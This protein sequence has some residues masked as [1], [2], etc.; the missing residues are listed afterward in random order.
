MSTDNLQSLL[1]QGNNQ[2]QKGQLAEAEATFKQIL[3]AQPNNHEAL[4]GLGIVALRA[5]QDQHAASFIAQALQLAPNN[6]RYYFQL[7]TIYTRAGNLNM[8]KNCHQKALDLAPDFAE[9]ML[10]LGATEC[11]LGN[12][13]EG[14]AL[15]EKAIKLKPEIADAHLLLGKVY[16]SI[17]RYRDAGEQFDE[18]LKIADKNPELLEHIMQQCSKADQHQMAITY[19][20]R[21]LAVGDAGNVR[22]L[23]TL[24]FSHEKLGEMDP[25]K[26][27]FEKAL[28]KLP[29]SAELHSNLGV[30]LSKSGNIPE[31]IK[32]YRK[33]IELDADFV[34]AYR[35][36][37]AFKKFTPEDKEIID[38]IEAMLDKPDLSEEAEAYL[39]FSLG[40]AYDDLKEYD[41]AFEHYARGNELTDKQAQFDPDEQQ[42]KFDAT[43]RVFTKDFFKKH[44]ARGSDSNRPIFI[45]GMPRSGTTL[46]EQIISAH[47]DVAGGD[48]LEHISHL[49][50]VA[51]Q[52]IA[53]GKE[54]PDCMAVASQEQLGH[55]AKFYLDQLATIS[56]AAPHVTDKLPYNF[57]YLGLIA[58]LFPNA[59]IV[60]CRRHPIDTCLSIYFQRF[61]T[62]N[63]YAYNLD[64]LGHYY[65]EY[66][67]LMEHWH[68][69]L[70]MKIL[71]V[72]YDEMVTDQEGMTRK[73]IDFLELPWNDA[74]LEFQKNTRSV[75]TASAWQVRQKI[76]T[77]SLE[78]WRRYESHLDPLKKALGWSE[79]NEKN[80]QA[81]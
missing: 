22:V 43:I 20:K 21:Y 18:T 46:T 77:G 48:E 27:F 61:I 62:G 60:H 81:S 54:Y 8:A 13:E 5:N 68:K 78:R 16:L 45:I 33:A 63:K 38:E 26:T 11:Q 24:G 42:K 6:P 67:R 23:S 4:F 69:E 15:I 10:S 44:T 9:S 19:G 30:V 39:R 7:G 1:V 58:M 75:K 66:E 57:M 35:N 3:T 79:N 40:K 70:P 49:A 59:K 2:L 34:H 50:S 36:L 14:C 51:D 53:S 73:I 55:M 56:P 52:I 65:R 25:A 41:I 17:G 37:T 47:P 31:A 72:N 64:H 76:Y 29:N 32:E 71:D 28:T 80:A 74:C 12:H